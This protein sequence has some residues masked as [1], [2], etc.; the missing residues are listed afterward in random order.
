MF[1]GDFICQ[2]D[3]FHSSFVFPVYFTE[4]SMGNESMFMPHFV[5]SFYCWQ[6]S[7]DYILGNKF[8][9]KKLLK[10]VKDDRTIAY[11]THHF[12]I[13]CDFQGNRLFCTLEMLRYSQ[14][15][16]EFLHEKCAFAVKN[17]LNF[18]RERETFNGVFVHAPVSLKE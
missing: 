17:Y 11:T 7:R 6:S 8:G 9:S 5:R 3:S 14:F 12:S 15:E 16:L 18:C 2:R 10:L 1:E 13:E 4:K